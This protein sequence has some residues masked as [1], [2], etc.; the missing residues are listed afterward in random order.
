[1][2]DDQNVVDF[3][4]NTMHHRQLRTLDREE[5]LLGALSTLVH[6]TDNTGLHP[7][8][9][10]VSS[11]GYIH[12]QDEAEEQLVNNGFYV[13]YYLPN[14][15]NI[16]EFEIVKYNVN[17]E[18]YSVTEEMLTANASNIKFDQVIYVHEKTFTPISERLIDT[19][20]ELYEIGFRMCRNHKRTFSE[21]IIEVFKDNVVIKII[22]LLDNYD[23]YLEET[24]FDLVLSS[25]ISDEP[26]G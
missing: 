9:I 5:K 16:A 14:I 3:F 13:H 7:M 21:K 25:E 2:S 19:L 26:T 8:P 11:T 15:G 20:E 12:P 10:G 6:M 23:T 24:K 4:D 22:W 18:N 17:H 1:M